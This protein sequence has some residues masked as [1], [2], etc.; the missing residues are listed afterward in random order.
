V[1]TADQSLKVLSGSRHMTIKAAD[2][3]HYAAERGRRGSALP[4]GWR[5]IDG[6]LPE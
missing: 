5:K 3:R 2:L 1:L 6:L 4:R